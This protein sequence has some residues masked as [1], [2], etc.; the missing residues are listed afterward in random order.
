MKLYFEPKMWGMCDENEELLELM[1][2]F[3]DTFIENAKVF[4]CIN[5]N[6]QVIADLVIEYPS[7]E[8]RTN[9]MMERYDVTRSQA[10]IAL[11]LPF[12]YT[13]LFFD[14]EEYCRHIGRLKT[15]RRI[16]QEVRDVIDE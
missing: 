13:P 8:E 12:K 2:E 15:L 9:A 14:K 7:N 6:P 11:M 16:L 4:E 3:L 5:F 1:P 10:Q